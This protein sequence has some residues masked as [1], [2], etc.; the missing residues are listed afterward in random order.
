L[1]I[2]E[3]GAMLAYKLVNDDGSPIYQS[4]S[5]IRYKVGQTYYEPQ[6]IGFGAHGRVT[7]ETPNPPDCV[8]LFAGNRNY[9]NGSFDSADSYTGQGQMLVVKILPQDVV[10]C[11]TDASKC[12]SRKLEVVAVYEKVQT[13]ANRAVFSVNPP[14]SQAE[15][16]EVLADID[17]DSL[18]SKIE[19]YIDRAGPRTIKQIQSRFK[20]ESDLDCEGLFHYISDFCGNLYSVD[21]PSAVSKRTMGFDYSDLY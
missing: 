12:C 1:A 2:T 14:G 19:N 13:E 15:E 5:P 10:D 16:A 21:S 17:S 3:D 11:N 8:G 4:W 9:W 18:A 20:G 7:I 6:A